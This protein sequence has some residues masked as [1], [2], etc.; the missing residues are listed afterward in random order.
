MSIIILGLNT[1]HG[2]SSAALINETGVIAAIAEER[3]NRKKH[4][5][6]FP[7]YAIEEC[8]R[9]AGIDLNEITD[10]AVARD[11]KANLMQK[12]VFVAKYPKSGIAMARKRF[13]VHRK[14]ASIED[15]IAESM[16]LS[17]TTIKTRFHHVEHHLAHIASAFFWSPY[18]SC[19]AFSNDG[20]GDFASIMFA[21]CQGNDIKILKRSYW[22]HSLGIFYTAMTQFIG[23]TKYGEEYKVMGLSAYGENRYKDFMSELVKYDKK[24][25]LRLN[26]EYFRHHMNDGSYESV[27]DGEVIIPTLWGKKLE[28]ELGP[29]RNRENGLTQR[30]KD[31]AASMQI[32]YEEVFLEM[33]ADLVKRTGKRNIVMAGGC[34]L[35]SVANGRMITE[36]YV[37]NAYFQPAA[38]DDGTAIGAA[39]YTLHSK[40]GIPRTGE[41]GHAF[42]G[43]EWKDEEIEKALRE[44]G[45]PFRKLSENELIQ[46]AAKEI[47]DGKIIGWFQG[48]EE[49]GPRA[50]GNRSILCNPAYPDMKAILNSRIKN[51]EHFRPFAPVCREEDLSICFEGTHPVPFMIVV[52]KVVNE[53]RERIPAVTHEDNTGRVQTVSQEQNKMYYDLIGVFKEITGVPVV[54]NT[55]FNENEPIVHTPRQAIDCFERTR[56]DG[57]GIG[58]FWMI[59]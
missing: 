47:A 22:P 8:L 7:A 58:S 12:A 26:L 37:D 52:Y 48:K 44:N 56:M 57:L 40:Y 10:I 29:A 5:A 14:V 41:V 38:S 3:I 39:L 59:K 17:K 19:C 18:E 54:L 27:K 15:T 4:C 55:S 30:D 36:G 6:D 33:V 43:T 46:T 34:A 49:W 9:I 23:F 1:N 21:N 11:P 45:R 25:G 31:I 16:G 53:W 13:A 42:W 32:R 2:D 51:R 50:L 35:N 20:A 24:F 28:S